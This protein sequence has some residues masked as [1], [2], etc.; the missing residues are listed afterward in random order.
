MARKRTLTDTKKL[1]LL[2]NAVRHDIVDMVY[3]A[4][5]GHPGG[6]LGMADIFTALYW[7]VLVHDPKKPQ[8]DKRDRLVLSNGHICAVHY[9]VLARCGYFPQEQLLTF[10]KLGGLQGHPHRETVPGVENSSGPLAE[11]LGQA[12]GMALAAKMDRKDHHVV[13]MGS[14]GE[15]QEGAVWEAVMAAAKWKLDNIIYIM[16]RNYIQI[17]GDTE[18][19]MPLDPVREKYEAFGWHVLEIDGHNLDEILDA[20]HAAKRMKRKPI[21]IIAVTILGKGVSYME[22]VAKWHG[23][24][25]KTEKEYLKA[26]AD[27]DAVHKKIQS[28]IY[29]Y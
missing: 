25:P 11:G 16:D 18:Q 21:L 1:A 27:L 8:W 12:V 3:N 24:P 19:V 2:A 10:R 28:E 29:D 26:I 5:S 7:N 23:S 6:A 9:S 13:V 15:Q 4:Q 20:L 17:E 14:D 22:D